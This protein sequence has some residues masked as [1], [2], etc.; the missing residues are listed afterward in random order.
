MLK[1][2]EIQVPIGTRVYLPEKWHDLL[3]TFSK[4]PH[5]PYAYEVTQ[6][7]KEGK[8][9][10]YVCT[11]EEKV[12]G[13]KWTIAFSEHAIR[14]LLAPEVPESNTGF[15]FKEFLPNDKTSVVL[16][17]VKNPNEMIAGVFHVEVVLMPEELVTF[18]FVVENDI[19]KGFT[20]VTYYDNVRKFTW[21]FLDGDESYMTDYEKMFKDTIV[22]RRFVAQSVEKLAR[23]LEGK[24]AIRNAKALRQR[25][26][27]HDISKLICED[28]LRALSHII[29]DKSSLQDC[30]KQLTPIKK[31]AIE[32][33]WKHNTHHPE[34]FQTPIDM[35]RIDIMEMCCD[36]YARSMQYHTNYLEFVQKQQETRFHFP[37]WMFAEIMHYCQVLN[38][39][40]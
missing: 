39:E 26:T 16:T 38:S 7:Q 40:F 18:I 24:G 34:H 14:Y 32:L 29:N 13:K 4:T 10:Y 6:V 20:D 9:K 12:K 31:D 15:S 23:Y 37:D 2:S 36:W 17:N 11:S 28:E 5:Y 30:N 19:G 33:H 21:K 3:V 35:S 8:D 27:V 1:I 22:H 25:A